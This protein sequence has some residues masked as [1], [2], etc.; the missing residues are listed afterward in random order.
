LPSSLGL[1]PPEFPIFH[2]NSEY[3]LG[4][5]QIEVLEVISSFVV[6][7]LPGDV[8][9][10]VAAVAVALVLLSP[11]VEA[12]LATM[13]NLVVNPGAEIGPHYH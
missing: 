9:V 1:S 6:L 11:S 10:A 8:L 3:F 7:L 5:I 12:A 2:Q 4:S 13:A